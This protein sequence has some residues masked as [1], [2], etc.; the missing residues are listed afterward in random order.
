MSHGPT[1]IKILE[2]LN[3]GISKIHGQFQ[4]IFLKKKLSFDINSTKGSQNLCYFED[5][6]AFW[7]T[8]GQAEALN[9]SYNPDRV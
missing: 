9:I 2:D 6:N 1:P 7:G 3:Q 4:E 8:Q 5:L